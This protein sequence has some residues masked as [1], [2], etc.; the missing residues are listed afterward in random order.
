MYKVNY[1]Y[2]IKRTE[3]TQQYDAIAMHAF[4][5]LNFSSF[6]V[7]VIIQTVNLGTKTIPG[8]PRS[9]LG[10]SRRGP[11]SLSAR[12]GQS[13]GAVRPVVKIGPQGELVWLTTFNFVVR[14]PKISRLGR[15]YIHLDLLISLAE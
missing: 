6:I 9:P 7:R 10:E 2:T 15:Y 14:E 1:F 5:Q 4:F 8:F 12:S 11:A 3:Q 13:L